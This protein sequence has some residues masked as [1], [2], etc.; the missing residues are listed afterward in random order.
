MNR[1]YR[2]LIA[3]ENYRLIQHILKPPPHQNLNNSIPANLPSNSTNAALFVGLEE[4]YNSSQ[5]G[6][7]KAALQK[8]KGFT[9]IKGPPGTGKTASILALL[10]VLLN[11]N[12]SMKIMLCA[13]SNDA[14]NEIMSRVIREG[15]FTTR[16]K[17]N[18]TPGT[19][20]LPPT[21]VD[22]GKVRIEIKKERKWGSKI[23]FFY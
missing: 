14:V 20:Y 1:E 19:E 23:E 7:I 10:S 21:V 5:I 18:N 8:E 15:L 16:T 3:C 17:E 12:K 2:A 6:A 11:S 13:P 4:L 22:R 9:L